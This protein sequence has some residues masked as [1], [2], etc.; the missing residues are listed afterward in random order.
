[1]AR[2]NDHTREELIQLTLEQVKEFLNHRPHHDLS[3]RK[4]ATMIGYVPSTLVNIFGSYNILLLHAV[5]QTL[6]EL[7][8]ESS[9]VIEKSENTRESLFQLAYCY[10]DFAQKHPFRWQLIFQHNMHGD[11]LPEWHAKRIE[12]MTSML[13]SILQT[14]A[15]QRSRDEILRIS[16]VLWAGVHGITLLSVDDK[17]FT[18]QPIDG[19][20]LI[21]NLINQ[22]LRDW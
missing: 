9:E 16:R 12:G 19:K 15:P 5:S 17:F 8:A 4:I 10:H 20:D 18:E 22:Y 11:P 21:D 14:L 6:D 1:M 3:L 7:A 2:R 13:E